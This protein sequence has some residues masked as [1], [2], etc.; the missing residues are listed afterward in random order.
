MLFMVIEQFKGGDA[1]P[2][3]ERF[4]SRGRM[5]PEGLTYLAS[6]V[7]ATRARCFQLM[8]APHPQLLKTWIS[9][10]DDLIDFEIVA[11][12][13]SSEFWAG[14]AGKVPQI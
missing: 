9:Q 3:G 14:D 12:V 4:R 11:V 5:L 13:T 10:W 6:W 2:I 1:G 8:E 7:D